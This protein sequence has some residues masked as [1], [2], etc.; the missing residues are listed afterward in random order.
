MFA[1]DYIVGLV[2]GEGSFTIYVRNK[3]SKRRVRVE[4]K[5]CL[6]LIEDDKGIL[7][8]LQK[9]FGCGSVYFQ[10]DARSNHKNCYRFEVYNRSQLNEIIIPF[11]KKHKLKLYSKSKDFKLFCKI[12]EM[13]NNNFHL[14]DKGLRQIDLIKQQMH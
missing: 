13:I 7:Y 2:D 10:K 8:D 12:M 11:F 14:T 5:F 6:K 9:F 3:N 4:P 1:S